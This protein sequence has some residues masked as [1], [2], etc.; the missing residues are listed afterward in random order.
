MTTETENPGAQEVIRPDAVCRIY[1]RRMV[2]VARFLAVIVFLMG[3]RVF[4]GWLLKVHLPSLYPW[5]GEM[6]ADTALCFCLLSLAILLGPLTASRR[7]KRILSPLLRWVVLAISSATLVEYMLGPNLFAHFDPLEIVGLKMGPDR[8]APNTAA[9]LL[10]YALA[11]SCVAR[12]WYA[13][14]Y[15]QMLALGGISVALIAL[16]NLLLQ[17]RIFLSAYS[18]SQLCVQTIFGIVLLGLIILSARPHRGMIA[19]LLRN[20]PAGIVARRMI[21]PAI[22]APIGIAWAAYYGLQAHYYD[23]G[24]ACSIIV[25]GCIIVI[26]SVTVR[27]VIELNRSDRERQRLAEAQLLSDARERGAREASRMKSDFVANVSHELRTPM[28]GVLGMTSLLLSSQLTPEQREQAETIRQSGD[29]LLTLVNEILDFSKIEAG[30]IELEPKPFSIPACLDEVVSLLG[31]GAR[32]GKINLIA[33]FARTGP[34]TY[35][36]DPARIRQVL[37]NLVGNAI[38]FTDEGDVTVEVTAVPLEEGFYDLQFVVADTGI[39]ISPGAMEVLFRPFQQVD[40]SAT[41]RHG[42]TGLGLAI[43]KRL[44]EL[45]GGT[46]TASS[47][48]GTGSTFRF[49][50]PM[51]AAPEEKETDEVALPAGCTLILAARE[52]RYPKLLR[53]QLIDWGAEVIELPNPLTLMQLPRN[54]TAVLMDRQD[55][56]IALAS[57]M[58][59][60]AVWKNVPRLLL[61]FDE[62]LADEEKSFFAKHLIKPLKRSHL[63]AALRDVTGQSQNI[64]VQRVATQPIMAVTHPLRVLLAEDNHINQKV[65]VALLARLGYR[66]DVAGNGRE[67]LDCVM[68]QPYDLVLLDIQMPEMDGIE[69]A[70]AMRK[71]LKTR[72]PR[73]AALTANAFP[74]AREQYLAQGFDDYLSKPLLSEALQQVLQATRPSDS[75]RS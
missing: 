24:F 48:I 70:A 29:A 40:N 51:A 47:V 38:K 44:V 8:M 18:E 27:S 59:L 73:L 53:Q 31:T 74:G 45:M 26:G 50:L 43:C 22:L 49:C 23:A 71:K 55:D 36:G 2:R 69:A 56:A 68:R 58:Q 30:K 41:R 67:A 21:A 7:W 6:T 54:V 42:G 1:S 64:K 4:L 32:R 20:N 72:C 25:F 75:L 34:A 5:R 37:I 46:I 39:G 66:T 61:D 65:A 57:R 33:R 62:E 16:I 11:I 3:F 10:F 63:A 35:V 17:A 14:N 60:E 28:N 15:A 13:A 19:V 52:G 12:G 9:A